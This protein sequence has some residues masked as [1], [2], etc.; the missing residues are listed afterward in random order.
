MILIRLGISIF[1][2]QH[3]PIKDYPFISLPHA[4]HHITVYEKC[5]A[6]EAF[7]EAPVF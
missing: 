6:S 2:N 4:S 7:H 1:Y 5:I 3:L